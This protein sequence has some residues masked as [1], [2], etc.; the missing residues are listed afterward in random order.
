MKKLFVLFFVVGCNQSVPT[1]PQTHPVATVPSK[2]PVQEAAKPITPPAPPPLTPKWIELKTRFAAFSQEVESCL[3]LIEVAP[4]QRKFR[5]K[6]EMATELYTRIP[7]SEDD[8]IFLDS[9]KHVLTMLNALWDIQELR[10]TLLPQMLDLTKE[11]I[12]LEKYPD[13]E[14]ESPRRKLNPRELAECKENI[15]KANEAKAQFVS[16]IRKIL[17]SVEK[18]IEEAEKP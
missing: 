8:A 2:P 16:S 3:K 12:A 11:G 15:K 1:Q 10:N 5:Q 6:I 4:N 13:K 7:S 14:P 9:S 17:Q 18:K